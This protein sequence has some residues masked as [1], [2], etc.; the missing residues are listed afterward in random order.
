MKEIFME[1]V[2]TLLS[3]PESTAT[4]E[5]GPIIRQKPGTIDI[6]YDSEGQENLL[7]THICFKTVLAMR[8]T[9]EVAIN[10][11]MPQAYSKIVEVLRSDWL[12]N[13]EM[14]ANEKHQS[15]IQGLQHFMVFFDHYGCVEV[16]AKSFSI[17]EKSPPPIGI[18]E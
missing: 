5:I 2:E 18:E 4:C 17:D 9:P 3:L 13:F 10:E 15:I 11:L 6:W 12:Q 8:F 14:V 7:W 1:R 16:I